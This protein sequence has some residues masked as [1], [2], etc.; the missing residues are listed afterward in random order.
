MT[1]IIQG[2]KVGF[3]LTITLTQDI[4]LAGPFRMNH[5]HYQRVI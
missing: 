2:N 1:G 5:G 3:C 4:G